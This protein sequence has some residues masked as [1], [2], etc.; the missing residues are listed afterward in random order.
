MNVQRKKIVSLLCT[1]ALG[2]V[3]QGMVP[4]QAQAVKY[5]VL[6]P[7]N[8]LSLTYD[9][10][11][12][13]Y[14]NVTANLTTDKG[15][16]DLNYYVTFNPA[17]GNRFFTN[18]SYSIPFEIYDNPQLPR[19]VLYDDLRATSADQ[20]LAGIFP[21]PSNIHKTPTDTRTF[22]VVAVPGGFAPA[23]TYT[24]TLTASFWAG[25]FKTGTLKAQ[26]QLSLV[27]QVNQILNIVA[28][29]VG[30]SFDYTAT[31]ATVDFGYL[32]AGSVRSLDL[33][34]RANTT[35]GLSIASTNGGI[36]R[37]ADSG[38]SSFI[39]YEL[40]VNGT[41]LTLPAGLSIPIVS[42]RPATTVD[43][44][45]FNVSAVIQSF[46]FPTEGLYSDILTVT[47]AKN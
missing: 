4:L 46:D 17:P 14:G 7:K 27:L 43:G 22:T 10:T 25:A 30:A 32:E 33:I 29:P 41:P 31:R 37:N 44:D 16:T 13:V 36:L 12:E 23:G 28:V 6:S 45:R 20:V 19:R 47:I 26:A 42:S 40:R 2:L 18:G 34:A 15:S 5:I 39:P 3:T 38:D 8:T 35:Y 9:S 11:Q 21:T 24:A 1:V